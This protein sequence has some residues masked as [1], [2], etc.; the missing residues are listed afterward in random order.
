MA[1]A[2]Q[3]DK[4]A[5]QERARQ[6][7]RVQA[8]AG[9]EVLMVGVRCL[10]LMEEMALL[11]PYLIHLTELAVVVEEVA[12]LVQL[13]LLMEETEALAEPMVAVAVVPEPRVQ[14]GLMERLALED[15]GLSSLHTI[16]HLPLYHLGHLPRR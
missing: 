11:I 9:Q 15:R 13:M 12:G 7:Q 16:K 6:V 10:V 2:G 1:Q 8:Q 3:E 5:A 4:L 14:R